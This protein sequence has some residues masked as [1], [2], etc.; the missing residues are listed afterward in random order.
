MRSQRRS[1]LSLAALA[2]SVGFSACDDAPIDSSTDDPAGEL[3]G[4]GAGDSTALIV[5]GPGTFCNP[6][7]DTTIVNA[8]L[9]RFAPEGYVDP[10][11]STTLELY[12][13]TTG[14]IS[15]RRFYGKSWHSWRS[16]GY[17]ASVV[18]APGPT[19]GVGSNGWDAA[20]TVL[21]A[22]GGKRDLYFGTWNGSSGG[23]ARDTIDLAPGGVGTMTAIAPTRGYMSAVTG[24]APGGSE[25]VFGSPLPNSVLDTS[26]A[27]LN[28]PVERIAGTMP[29]EITAAGTMS[30]E[31]IV[32]PGGAVSLRRNPAVDRTDSIYLYAGDM[33]T[34]QQDSNG[35]WRPFLSDV[36]TMKLGDAS[37]TSLGAPKHDF[38]GVPTPGMVAAAPYAFGFYWGDP[39]AGGSAQLN[40]FAT[41]RDAGSYQYRLFGRGMSNGN[42]ERD[43]TEYG[44]PPTVGVDESFALSTGMVWWDGARYTSTLREN[45]FGLTAGG[46]LIEFY[47]DGGSWQWGQVIANTPDGGTFA[48]LSSAV[49]DTTTY[50]R[51]SLFVRSSRGTI[52]EFYY[53]IDNNV[54]N[55]WNWT[56][57]SVVQ[58]CNIY[59]F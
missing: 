11:T 41:A 56:N 38:H 53:T 3:A 47:W 23:V 50:K 55:G 2:L 6:Y 1:Q 57:L 5:G 46:K 43:W 8:G 28:L 13:V 52:Y 14:G 25:N 39:N 59:V 35:N 34:E 19:S 20:L 49:I 44:I 51:L 58:P 42:L 37:W 27:T 12:A 15:A 40:V 7:A 36:V 4:V 24:A 17:N 9:A 48:A 54:W 31:Q 32:G 21:P 18:P 16:Y 45:L 26:F 30:P 29:S 10:S 33:L 22:A